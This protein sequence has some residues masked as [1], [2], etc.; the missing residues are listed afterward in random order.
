MN[1]IYEEEMNS[2]ESNNIAT[3]LDYYFVTERS[4]PELL[5]YYAETCDSDVYYYYYVKVEIPAEY[6]EDEMQICKGIAYDY[7]KGNPIDEGFDIIKP[8]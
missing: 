2:F 1:T 8:I 7:C 3:V 5:P 4:I 6:R